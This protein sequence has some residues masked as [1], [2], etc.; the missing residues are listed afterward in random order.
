[1]TC[2]SI[3]L[4]LILVGA[5]GVFTEPWHQSRELDELGLA[6]FAVGLVFFAAGWLYLAPDVL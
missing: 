3:G 4:G 6:L 2:M 5:A 1:M